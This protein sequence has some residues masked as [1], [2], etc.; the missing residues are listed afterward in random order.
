MST[1]N[2]FTLSKPP[3]NDFDLSDPT[4]FALSQSQLIECLNTEGVASITVVSPQGRL[5][6]LYS[7]CVITDEHNNNYAIQ[8]NLSDNM[9]SPRFAQ[10]PLTE[11]GSTVSFTTKKPSL[12]STG[13]RIAGIKARA[14][15]FKG[16][17]YAQVTPNFITMPFGQPRISG[18]IDDEE[19]L[20]NVHLWCAPAGVIL[21]A[22]CSAISNVEETESLF[23]AICEANK[24][25]ELLMTD[26][27]AQ[28]IDPKLPCV[29]IDNIDEEDDDVEIHPAL[30]ER[31]KLPAFNEHP[32]QPYLPQ[33]LPVGTQPAPVL[34]QPLQTCSTQSNTNQQVILVKTEDSNKIQI[35]AQD[36]QARLSLFYVVGQVGGLTPVTLNDLSVPVF[37]SSFKGVLQSYSSI[38][39]EKM[40]NLISSVSDAWGKCRGTI[41]DLTVVPDTLSKALLGGCL[42]HQPLS[43]RLSSVV[44]SKEVNIL[45]FGPQTNNPERVKQIID[46]KERVTA[47]QLNDV[48]DSQRI[49]V[50][51]DIPSF[52]NISEIE[53]TRITMDNFQMVSSAIVNVANQATHTCKPIILQL[54]QNLDDFLLSRR[55]VVWFRQYASNMRWL[56]STITVLLQNV[57]CAFAKLS[58]SFIAVEALTSNPTDVILRASI[59]EDDIGAINGAIATVKQFKMAIDT[60]IGSNA[61]LSEQIHCPQIERNAIDADHRKR[62]VSASAPEGRVASGDGRGGPSYQPRFHNTQRSNRL[63]HRGN[64]RPRK[65]PSELGMFYLC[66]T[67]MSNDDV[68]PN[69]ATCFIKG[70]VKKLCPDFACVGKACSYGLD[71]EFAHVTNYSKLSQQ[72]FDSICSHFHKHNIGWLSAGML[73][74]S[75]VTLSNQFASLKGDANGKFNTQG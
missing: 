47:E 62:P 7:P 59:S 28:R 56:P 9:S 57:F 38:R 53:D 15:A 35:Q 72:V 74:K 69:D 71:C 30:L 75:K 64:I 19:T 49:Q 34:P 25:D 68:F 3:S 63:Q 8:G 10:I 42:S 50:K 6:S 27:C 67:N 58:K 18:N 32:S 41:A 37:T 46:Y 20:S 31:F 21:D 29:N 54:F 26:F 16:N 22:L 23:Q 70:Q 4:S 60:A 13:N 12:F 55:V 5:T 2:K 43:Q 39:Q 1:S 51:T 73:E 61:A 52:G 17:C 66:N 45:S 11:L 24:E 44:S 48:P 33:P 40:S 14:K 36:A 65:E